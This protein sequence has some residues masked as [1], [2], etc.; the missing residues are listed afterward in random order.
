MNVDEI[1]KN[2]RNL[3]TREDV[4]KVQKAISRK[5]GEI[6]T[7]EIR[8]YSIGDTVSFNHKGVE[9]QGKII[10]VNTVSVSVKTPNCTW[11]VSPSFL[12]K[13]S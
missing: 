3:N 10:K 11:K 6:R 8:T 13:V 1:V 2:I 5:L 12:T 4:E 7:D 9:H